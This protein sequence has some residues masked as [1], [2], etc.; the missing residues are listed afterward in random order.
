MTSQSNNNREYTM[1]DFPRHTQEPFDTPLF[2]I[3]HQQQ[4][5]KGDKRIKGLV[6]IETVV[7]RRWGNE[8]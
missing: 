7:Q 6:S 2:H 4:S 1:S 8:T 3:S 5:V